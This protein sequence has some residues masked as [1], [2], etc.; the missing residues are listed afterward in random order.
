[1]NS[2]AP[3]L[4]VQVGYVALTGVLQLQLV[5]VVDLPLDLS[6]Q[7]HQPHLLLVVLVLE[8]S[9]AGEGVK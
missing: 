2:E 7:L 4:F 8:T 1:L 3:V 6:H 9:F 5:L